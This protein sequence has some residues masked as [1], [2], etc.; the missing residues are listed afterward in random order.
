VKSIFLSLILPAHNEETR[1]PHALGQ[2][3][4]FLDSQPYAS[5]VIVVENASRDHTLQVAQGLCHTFPGL[6]VF[7]EDQPGKGRAVRRGM[8]EAMGEH[9][10]FADVDF[11]MPADQIPRFLPPM[12]TCDIVI[13]SR[14]APGAVRYG[15]PVHRHLTG[16]MFN[17]LIRALVLPSLQ[18]TQCGF[19]CF[20]ARAA[21]DLFRHQ[22]LNGWSFDVELLAI[23]QM[24]GYSIAEIGIPWTFN[25]DSRVNILRDSFS[26]FFDLLSIRAN[27]RQGVYDAQA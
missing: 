10:F 19:K 21:E 20:R 26:M 2:A 4:T 15:E 23:A 5:E 14:E 1:L 13:A 27:L 17:F 6:R 12:N 24:R 7:H 22:T 18:D 16:R 8:L 9:R 25:P 11:S 3:F